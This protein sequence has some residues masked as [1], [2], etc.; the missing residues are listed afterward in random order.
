MRIGVQGH[1]YGGVSQELLHELGMDASSQEQG[2]AGV[3]EVVEAYFGQ[4]GILE[5]RF[6]GPVYEVFGVDGR[7]NERKGL[8]EPQTFFE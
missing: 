3:P 1:G 6:E 7:S 2:G 4:T 5:E 8:Q